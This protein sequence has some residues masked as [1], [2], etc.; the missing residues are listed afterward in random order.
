[1]NRQAN[2]TKAQKSRMSDERV[3]PSTGNVFADLGFPHAEGRL[4]KAKL[5]VKIAQLIEEKGS[6]QAQAA[7]RTAL[8]LSK[9]SR[10]LRGQ[11]S[12]FS[13]DRLFVILTRLGHSS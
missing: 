13:A 2:T 6:T 3:E 12:G 8:N 10:L 9:V 4:L 7:E 5:A 1:M 11:L